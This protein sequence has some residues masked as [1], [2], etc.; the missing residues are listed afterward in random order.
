[1]LTCLSPEGGRGKQGG[2]VG[3]GG[4]KL[5]YK[6]CREMDKYHCYPYCRIRERPPARPLQIRRIGAIGVNPA[7]ELVAIAPAIFNPLKE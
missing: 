1:M 2:G 3:D 7:K 5:K 6:M 4:E